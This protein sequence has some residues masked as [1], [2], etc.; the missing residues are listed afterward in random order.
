MIEQ[1]E[2]SRALTMEEI[3]QEQQ[4]QDSLNKIVV[5]T[6]NNSIKPS[7]EETE[8]FIL[9]LNN[10]FNLGI[11]TENLIINIQDTS[12]NTKGFFMPKEHKNHYET[13]ADKKKLYYICLSSLYLNNTPFETIAH[14]TAHLIN[15]IQGHTSKGNYHTKEFKKQAESLFLKVEKGKYGYNQTTETEEFKNLV[16]EFKPSETAFKI[17]QLKQ[18][19]KTATRNLLFICGCGCRIRTAKTNKETGQE[20]KGLCLNCNTEFKQAQEKGKGEDDKGEDE[21]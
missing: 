17:Y 7:I 9:F 16:Q 20:F 5:Q 1:Q 14:E 8:R 12:T 15:E 4:A 18:G 11:E 21:N 19:K 6:L 2:S 10:R 3:Q 13:T